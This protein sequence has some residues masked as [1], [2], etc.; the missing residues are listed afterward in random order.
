[1]G[2]ALQ[3]GDLHDALHN[4]SEL[5]WRDKGRLLAAQIA[6]GVHELHTH[7]VG[8]PCQSCAC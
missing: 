2:P 1:M 8:S 3:G 5:T 6:L 4:S 7:K